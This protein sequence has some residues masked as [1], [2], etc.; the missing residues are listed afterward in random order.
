MEAV[1]TTVS[2]AL[3]PLIALSALS[4]TSSTSQDVLAAYPTVKSAPVSTSAILAAS[5]TSW[6]ATGVRSA[7]THSTSMILPASARAVF[8]CAACASTIP[9]ATNVLEPTTTTVPRRHVRVA[10]RTVTA[11]SQWISVLPAVQATTG[12]MVVSAACPIACSVLH[13]TTATGVKSHMEW[14]M[15]TASSATTPH[16]MM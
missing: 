8:H 9:A 10:N 7:I 5:T 13:R 14:S 6:L 12:T 3:V 4:D 16:S 2:N 11:V 15:G 1:W